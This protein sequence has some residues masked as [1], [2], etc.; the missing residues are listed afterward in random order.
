MGVS[1]LALTWVGWLKGEK[2]ASTCV[3][4]KSQPKCAQAIA[5]QRKCTEALAKRGRK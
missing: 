4:I 2:L 3:Q 1:Q 5:S